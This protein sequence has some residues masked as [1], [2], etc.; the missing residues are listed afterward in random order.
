MTSRENKKN[1]W[2][3]R[4]KPEDINLLAPDAPIEYGYVLIIEY[5]DKRI[6]IA[7][8][9]NP[10]RYVN[11]LQQLA[12]K[13]MANAATNIR[14]SPLVRRVETVKGNLIRKLKD[15]KIEQNPSFYLVDESVL[16]KKISETFALATFYTA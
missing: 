8:S 1:V 2:V 9:K 5:E 3:N 14:I 4:C 10:T 6:F 12:N 7:S 16:K 15:Y 11:S 13:M